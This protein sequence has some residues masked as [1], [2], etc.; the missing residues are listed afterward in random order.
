MTKLIFWKEKNCEKINF[1]E[2][3]HQEENVFVHSNFST[4]FQ[5][6]FCKIVETTTIA[7][8]RQIS[9]F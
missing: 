4:S 7:S 5:K 9:W 3:R 8:Q 6:G 1:P 2:R